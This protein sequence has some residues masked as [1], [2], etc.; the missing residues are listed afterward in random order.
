MFSLMKSN[1]ERSDRSSCV[2]YPL[3]TFKPSHY[4][5]DY[6]LKESEKLCVSRLD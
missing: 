2:L 6:C 5:L 1:V 3:V 4:V